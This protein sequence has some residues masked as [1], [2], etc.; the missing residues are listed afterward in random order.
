MF[1]PRSFL[2]R[3]FLLNS[4]L[5]RA[6]VLWLALLLPA[7]GPPILLAYFLNATGP[8]WIPLVW[9][10]VSIGLAVLMKT[11]KAANRF[12]KLTNFL[13]LGLGLLKA[14]VRRTFG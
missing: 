11:Q 13:W 9:A 4:C 7:L 6:L 10:A 2:Q 1:L 3:S 8:L 14:R 5:L 12:I